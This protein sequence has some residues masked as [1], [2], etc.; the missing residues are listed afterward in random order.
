MRITPTAERPRYCVPS[1]TP[2]V[3]SVSLSDFDIDEI[4]EYLRHKGDMVAG[5][6]ADDA[7]DGA[8]AGGMFIDPA[9][10]DRIE[11]LALC[12][13]L[14]SARRFVLDMVSEQIGRPL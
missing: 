7:H 4:R 8:T 1:V 13:Q 9:D 6:S 12:G 11:T 10:L 3:E 2:F 14:D 5:T